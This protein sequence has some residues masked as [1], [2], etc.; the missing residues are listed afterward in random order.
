MSIF[1]THSELREINEGSEQIREQQLRRN[2]LTREELLEDI[3][4]REEQRKEQLREL[5][6]K[7]FL[8]S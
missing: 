7:L 8:R 4:R 1:S 6:D 3:R 2:N 5:R